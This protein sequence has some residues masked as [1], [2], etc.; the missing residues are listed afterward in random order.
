MDLPLFCRVLGPDAFNLL[1]EAVRALH[2]VTAPRQWRGNARVERE[3]GAV[4][5]AICGMLGLP[6]GAESVPV[7]VSMAPDGDGE[8]WERRFGDHLLRSTIVMAGPPGSGLIRESMGAFSGTVALQASPRGLGWP[9][10]SARV[11][12]L[13]L[14]APL[15]PE[16]R[17]MESDENGRFRFD[18][19]LAV[20]AIGPVIR[21][22]GTLRPFG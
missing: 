8:V 3:P 4:R 21:Y 13:P 6:P 14:P 15:L 22:S 11:L 2:L 1:P 5:G 12:G 18:V 19:S 7:T 17:T 20:P 9:V 16:S 10:R